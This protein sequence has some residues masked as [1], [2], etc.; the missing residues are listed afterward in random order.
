MKKSGIRFSVAT[1]VLIITACSSFSQGVKPQN[2]YRV[3]VN[4]RYVIENGERQSKYYAIGQLISDSLGRL[5]TE[6][7]FNWETHYPDSYR[8]HYFEDT[9]KVRTD[10]FLKEKLHHFNVYQYSPN[11][12]LSELSIFTVTG[13]DTTLTVR[14]KYSYNSNGKV[15]KVVGYNDKEKKGFTAKYKYNDFNTEIKRKVRA[16]RAAPSDSILYLDREVSYDTI[17]RVSTEMLTV[18]KKGLPRKTRQTQY[19]YDVKGNIIGELVN[20]KSG[21][22]IKRIEYNYRPDNRIK[23]MAVY[24]ASETLIDYQ[25]WRYEIYK[26]SDRRYRVFE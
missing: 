20:D 16:R 23:G 3:T 9:V 6:I 18:E 2:I 1:V 4:S 10:F 22:L 14:E 12:A 5:H 26:T 13:N 11:G 24:D 19:T 21:N 15:S 25:A 7:D 17:G 8:W